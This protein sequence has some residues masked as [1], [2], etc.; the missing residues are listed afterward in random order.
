MLEA[1]QDPLS[2]GCYSIIIFSKIENVKRIIL[3]QIHALSESNE[4]SLPISFLF[5]FF[6]LGPHRGVILKILSRFSVMS[7]TTLVLRTPFK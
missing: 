4:T 1:F 6:P 7:L 2:G 3:V 5:C